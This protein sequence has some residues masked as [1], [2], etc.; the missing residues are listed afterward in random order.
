MPS[1]NP[2]AGGGGGDSILINAGAI[3]DADFGATPVA[4]AGRSLIE[5]QTSG[6]GPAA[7]SGQTASSVPMRISNERADV[8]IVNTVTETS[9]FSESIPAN[10]LGTARGLLITC[11]GD[12][13]NNSGGTASI[14]LKIKLG[15]T[16][17]YDSG[18][19]ATMASNVTFRAWSLWFILA[20]KSATNSQDMVGAFLLGGTASPP[21]TGVGGLAASGPIMGPIKGTAA[22]DTTSAKTLDVTI[23]LSTASANYSFN[24]KTGSIFLL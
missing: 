21:T 7:V 24:Y 10:A 11:G 18:T 2:G 6:S 12:L 5:W 3:V 9:I 15:A 20:N 16:T 8:T 17:I 19:S 22:E 13:Q 4:A 14:T 1:F 23:T